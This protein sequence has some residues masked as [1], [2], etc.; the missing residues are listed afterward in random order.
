MM[1]SLSPMLCKSSLHMITMVL[2]EAGAGEVSQTGAASNRGMTHSHSETG[3]FILSQTAL[4]HNRLDASRK[5]SYL[6]LSRP[7]M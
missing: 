5:S 1:I 3:I 2:N 4:H 6:I 7:S